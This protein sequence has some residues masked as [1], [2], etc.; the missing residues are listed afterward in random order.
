MVIIRVIVFEVHD[1]KFYVE[2]YY[3]FK[4]IEPCGLGVWSK[5]HNVDIVCTSLNLKLQYCVAR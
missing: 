4:F 2:K 5:L 1:L 3:E